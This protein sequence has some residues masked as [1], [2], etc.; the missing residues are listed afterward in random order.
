MNSHD[1]KNLSRE[2]C[3]K[4]IN[5]EN[6]ECVVC[7]EEIKIG[8]LYLP[9]NHYQTCFECSVN[10]TKECSIC[11][12]PIKYV[13]HYFKDNKYQDNFSSHLSYFNTPYQ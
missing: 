4:I 12:T 9:C 7:L 8:T 13:I 11:R 2:L 6:T 3:K 1:F 10:V 5:L